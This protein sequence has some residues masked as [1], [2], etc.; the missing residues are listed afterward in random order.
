MVIKLR[1]AGVANSG[2]LGET[3]A[4][5]KLAGLSSVQHVGADVRVEPALLHVHGAGDG[6][7]RHRRLQPQAAPE[8]LARGRRRSVHHEHARVQGLGVGVAPDAHDGDGPAAAPVPAGWCSVTLVTAPLPLRTE[9]PRC[10]RREKAAMA[11]TMSA[12][13]AS[14]RNFY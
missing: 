7:A 12:P 1:E 2:E 13:L 6:A 14:A 9:T 11:S 4:Q 8:R 5:M 10:L 3:K